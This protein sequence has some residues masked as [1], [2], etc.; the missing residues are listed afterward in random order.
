M[1]L[2][3][4]GS[5]AAFGPPLQSIWNLK[6]IVRLSPAMPSLFFRRNGTISVGPNSEPTRPPR[7]PL[8]RGV[9]Q[10]PTARSFGVLCPVC[11]LHRL[12]SFFCVFWFFFGVVKTHALLCVR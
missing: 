5:M 10:R 12:A 11:P 9:C 1:P 3:S 7:Q 6:R 2:Y 8:A 4:F